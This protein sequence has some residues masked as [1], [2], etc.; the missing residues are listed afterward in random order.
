MPCYLYIDGKK[1]E[2]DEDIFDQMVEA[3]NQPSTPKNTPTANTRWRPDGTY[4]KRPLDEDYFK[5]YYQKKLKIP[6]KC[7]DC[8]RTIS[9]KYNLS[10]H[11]QT[12]ACMSN[13]RH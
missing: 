13:R 11:R 7:P 5:T 8:G 9:S 10:K 1:Q 6:F 4:D 12:N 2:M 3:L